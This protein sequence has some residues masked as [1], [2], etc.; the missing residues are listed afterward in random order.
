VSPSPVVCKCGKVVPPESKKGRKWCSDYCRNQYHL[1]ALRIR[2]K[3]ARKTS[4]ATERS[5]ELCN[6]KFRLKETGQLRRFCS[7][8]CTNK[9]ARLRREGVTQRSTVDGRT[10]RDRRPRI[11]GDFLHEDLAQE[12][13]LAS[14]EGRAFDKSDFYARHRPRLEQ[15]RLAEWI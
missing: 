10:Q 9:Q 8:Y 1:R 4:R 6:K 2:Q 7:P 14:L 12:R 11:F 3:E 15:A 5:C 13:A